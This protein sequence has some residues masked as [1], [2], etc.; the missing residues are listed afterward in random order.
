VETKHLFFLLFLVIIILVNGCT[1]ALDSSSTTAISYKTFELKPDDIYLRYFHHP[2]YS[3]EYP[4]NFNLVDE[5]LS[6]FPHLF[7][8]KTNIQFAIKKADTPYPRLSIIIEKPG[9]YGY[10]NAT[11]KLE[12]FRSLHSSAS[13]TDLNTYKIKIIG[14]TALY[15]EAFFSHPEEVDYSQYLSS[16]RKCFFDYAGL[17]W[18]IRLDWYYQ[19]NESPEVQKYFDHIIETFK[20]LE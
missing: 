18:E 15:L 7:D 13:P 5:N 14:L 2:L 1:G 6:D 11:E 4:T 12:Y 9:N 16:H 8:D 10:N 19:G 17:I 3:F 20:I